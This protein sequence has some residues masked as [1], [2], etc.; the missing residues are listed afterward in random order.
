MNKYGYE[1]DKLQI[2]EMAALPVDRNDIGVKSLWKDYALS[3]LR[4]DEKLEKPYMRSKKID[5][6]LSFSKK[7]DAYFICSRA[8]GMEYDAEWA[9]RK[10]AECTAL[11][12]EKLI[13]DIETRVGCCSICGA[14][15]P[16][17]NIS[18]TICDDC[19]TEKIQMKISEEMQVSEGAAAN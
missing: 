9:N 13:S 19:R 1:A 16:W 12:N 11:I 3:R 14:E 15:L 18:R 6:L 10:R 7:L 17:N 4:G 2:Y 8:W 5:D